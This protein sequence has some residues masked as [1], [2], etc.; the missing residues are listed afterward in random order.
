MGCVGVMTAWA[1]II[2]SSIGSDVVYLRGYVAYIGIR[3]TKWHG[4]AW[5]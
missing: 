3:Y 2:F 1:F 5:T 4:M